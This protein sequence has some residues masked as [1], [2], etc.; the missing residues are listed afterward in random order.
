STLLNQLAG[1]V[2]SIVSAE[3][4]TTRDTVDTM[5]KRGG[6]LYQFVDTA[7]I[8]RKGKT[9]LI[10]EKLSVI[11][12]RKSLERADVALLVVDAEQG[13]TGG[14]ATIASYAKDSGCSV[15]IVMNKWD[16]ALEAA[17]SAAEAEDARGSAHRIEKREKPEKPGK[18]G[19]GKYKDE[20]A[21]AKALRTLRDPGMLM[22]EYERLVREKLKFLD[23]AP[24][25]F[26]AANTGDRIGKLYPLIDKVA[27]SRAR[28]V[29]TGEINRW[30][31][32]VDLERGT[33]PVSRKIKIFYM[34]QAS[35]SPPTF[36]LF[37]NQ[38]KRLHFSYERFLEN[39]LREGFDFTGSPIRFLQKVREF[40]KRNR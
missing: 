36:V 19:R 11:M 29:S 5:V 38:D 32:K 35:T 24:V 1:E 23:F 39:R 33:S 30:L 16:L 3:A 18:P 6:K 15:I 7:G 28:R 14:D 4:G 10:A 22:T 27:E 25:V 2:R 26:L 12:A 17:R 9:K 37:T 40:K 8:R 34:T 21:S 13:V 20:S 31:A